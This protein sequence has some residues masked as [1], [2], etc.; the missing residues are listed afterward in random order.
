L[1]RSVTKSEVKKDAKKRLYHFK[2]AK[3]KNWKQNEAK[4]KLLKAKQNEKK[5]GFRFALK[6]NEELLEEKQREKRCLKRFGWKQK[7]AAKRSEHFFHAKRIWFRV[8]SLWS[9]IFFAK[10]AHP[11]P[12]LLYNKSWQVAKN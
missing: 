7:F 1:L 3:W 10:P 2:Q 12:V 6:Q 11:S 5:R 4:E 8:V 9:E